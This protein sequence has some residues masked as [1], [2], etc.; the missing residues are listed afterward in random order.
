MSYPCCPASPAAATVL[1][2]GKGATLDRTST[3]LLWLR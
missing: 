3:R 1:S 2:G